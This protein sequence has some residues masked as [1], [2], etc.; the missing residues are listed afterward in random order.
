[1]EEYTREKHNNNLIT[2]KRHS[3][4]KV[5][6]KVAV[7]TCV[8]FRDRL[9][10]IKQA[11]NSILEQDYNHVSLYIY[12]DGPVP[13]KLSDYLNDILR[14]TNVF[15]IYGC[16]NKGLANGLNTLIDLVLSKNEY[17][18]I[19]RMDADDISRKNRISEQVK[20]F[21]NSMEVDV[22]GSF[23]SEFGSSY[24]LETKKL[25]TEHRELKNFS[26]ARCPFVH[27]TVMFRANVFMAGIRYPVNTRLTED[28]ALWINLLL[29]GSNFANVPQVLLDYRL[30][31]STVIRRTG[32]RKAWSEIKMRTF[33]MI[34]SRQVS[35]SNVAKIA[36]RIIFHILP[37]K[38]LKVVYKYFR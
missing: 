32:I 19:A 35:A 34:E 6:Q 22:L 30:N 8:Y 14:F 31:E 37:S 18:F 24:A 38:L 25:P 36:S 2:D 15:V 17:Q 16:E 7:I 12:C 28:M 26:V 9:S 13:S 1:M 10:Y 3:A 11:F 23:C 5:N 27:P 4:K 20:Y 21:N 29:S 33:F